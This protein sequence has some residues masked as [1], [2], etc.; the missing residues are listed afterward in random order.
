[1]SW[2]WGAVHKI[3][4]ISLTFRQLSNPKLK[5]DDTIRVSYENEA[6]IDL[7]RTSV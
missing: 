3:R 1:L 6:R 2:W 7:N 4:D 5:C